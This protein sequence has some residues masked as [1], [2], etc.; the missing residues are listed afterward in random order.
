MNDFLQLELGTNSRTVIR[1]FHRRLQQWYKAEG[2]SLPWREDT[3]LYRTVVSEFMCQQTQVSTVIP[4]FNRWIASFPDFQSL[5]AASEDSI[6]KHWEGLGYYRR[7]QFLHELAKAL[8]G[9]RPPRTAG[10]WEKLPG[11]GPYT[12]AA[13][14]SIAC[15]RAV[16]C[17][18]GN[19]V[20]VLSRL[21]GEEAV[22]KS[23]THAARHFTPLANSL[24]DDDNPGTHNQAMMEL[25]ATVCSKKKPLCIVCPVKTHC[26][27]GS[28]RF[29]EELPRIRRS[30]IVAQTLK[31][32]WIIQN[33][34]MLLHRRPEESRRMARL[35]ELPTAEQVRIKPQKLINVRSI[36]R[37]RTITRY[38][39]T[40]IIH[41]PKSLNKAQKIE[42]KKN[43]CRWISLKKLDS[44]SLSGPH[45]RWVQEIL[46]G[47]QA[48][49]L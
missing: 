38:R 30:K 33:G 1:D 46:K 37:K 5:A 15:G 31:R 35:H 2:R 19:V 14:S 40:E 32:I 41:F 8:A 47:E 22:F 13:I 6:L 43:N 18:D 7:A 24:L 21:V 49:G 23:G 26:R 25:G 48:K 45:R 27:S 10:A 12:A 11:V 36:I 44:L 28:D 9:S 42:A 16:A 34:R 17:V 29:A 3:S 39:I 20:R 4:Y